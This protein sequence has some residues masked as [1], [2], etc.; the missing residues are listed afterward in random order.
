MML[1]HLDS[2][3]V[4]SMWKGPFGSRDSISLHK[5]LIEKRTA[6]KKLKN[7]L[8]ATKANLNSFFL[9]KQLC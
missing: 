6:K 5:I 1:Q 7:Q 2:T 3:K 9:M 4:L 8:A